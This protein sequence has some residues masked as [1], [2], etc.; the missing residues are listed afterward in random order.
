MAHILFKWFLVSLASILPSTA[1]RHPVY[2]SVAEIEYNAAEKDLGI[3]CK[4]FTDDFEK[5]LR[6]TYNTHVDLLNKTYKADMDKL[7]NDYVQKHFKVAVDGKPVMLRYLGYE[8][9]EEGIYC[10]FEGD[11]IAAVHKVQLT[12][13]L[14][15]EYQEQQMQLIHCTVNGITKNTKLNNPDDQAVF[16]F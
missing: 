5:I 8:Q 14:L 16:Q 10:Y 13:N 6:R 15:Y 4:I 12:D 7:V 2:V 3:S 11:H 9:I 1:N